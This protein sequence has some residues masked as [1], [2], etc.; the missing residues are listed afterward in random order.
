MTVAFLTTSRR[1]QYNADPQLLIDQRPNPWGVTVSS[2]GMRAHTNIVA[3]GGGTS[4]PLRC[5]PLQ[6]ASRRP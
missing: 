2:V 5:R 1:T 4:Q 3:G 6:R